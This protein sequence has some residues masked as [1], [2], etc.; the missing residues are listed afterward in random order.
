MNAA[1]EKKRAELATFIQRMAVAEPSI[2]GAVAVGSVATGLA[3]PDSD[4]DAVVFMDPFDLYAIP[5]EFKWRPDQGTFHGIFTHVE[6]AIQFDFKRLDLAEWSKPSHVWPGPMCAELSE[7]WLAYDRA[8]QTRPL[9]DKRTAYTDDVRQSRLD[10]AVLWLDQLLGASKAE[11]TW[12]TLGP[13]MAHDRLHAAYDYVIQALF[14]YHRRWRPWRSRELAYMFKLPWLPERLKE[15][16]LSAGNA[17]SVT[18]EGY[19]QRL[20]ILR[21]FFAE[22]VEQCQQD[23]MYGADAAGEAFIRQCGEPGRDWNMEEWNRLHQQRTANASNGR[24]INE[25]TI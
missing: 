16:I 6:D 1:T 23:G 19:G 5:A 13:A 2:Q 25:P 24:D 9:I 14:A 18:Q 21:R 7:G 22:L 4:I 17:L 3:R 12:A 20:A 11:R 10:E 15:Q 8:G